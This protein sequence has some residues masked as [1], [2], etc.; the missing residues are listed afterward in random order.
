MP[1]LPRAELRRIERAHKIANTLI[2]GID[3]AS[4]RH[5]AVIYSPTQQPLTNALEVPND[6]A[7]FE[8]FE[9]VLNGHR[10]TFP[11]RPVVFAIEASGEHWKPLAQYFGERGHEAVYV[12]PLFVKRTRD[13]D[14]YTPRANDPKDTVRIANLARDGRYFVRQTQPEV[15]EDLNHLIRSWEQVSKQL[16]QVRLRLRALQEKYFPE[17]FSAFA[18]LLGAASLAILSRWPFPD[19]MLAADKSEMMAALGVASRN[20]LGAAKLGKLQS[21]A[22][23]SVGLKSGRRGARCRLQHLVGQAQFFSKQAAHIIRQLRGLLEEID[24]A[25]R[26]DSLP[27]VGFISTARLLG[28]LGDLANF[29]KVDQVIDFAGLSLIASDS[30]TFRSSRHI[31]RRGRKALRRILYEITCRFV[32]FANTARRKFLRCR[33]QGKL[34]RQAIVAAIVHLLRTIFA[35]VKG[36]QAYR[37]P[38]V[39]DP[40][41][42]ELAEL[43]ARWLVR[44]QELKKAA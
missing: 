30:G 25:K 31:S 5:T 36:N 41:R 28:H 24:Y 9:K 43:E 35:V 22:A 39:D 14:D 23:T 3:P 13:V 42:D 26:L 6:R 2:V 21:L 40:L 29:D 10:A 16:A 4:R 44:Q 1:K 17:Y 19:D 15:F 38:S 18:N 27:G 33:L 8:R 32:R 20:K 11:S 12:P 37:H 7:G 34:Y